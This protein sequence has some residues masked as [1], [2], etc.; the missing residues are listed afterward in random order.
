MDLI[1]Q[2]VSTEPEIPIPEVARSQALAADAALP[3]PPARA[4]ARHPLAHLLQVRG[5]LAGG[6]HKPNTAVAQAYENAKAGMTRITTET[7]AGQWGSR[8]R[9]PA[10]F[11]GLECKV[12]MV[13]HYDQK[14]YRRSMMETWG[15]SVLRSSWTST[16]PAARSAGLAG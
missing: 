4:R 2:E 16:G 14:P 15:A 12:Y 5:R 9:S 10:G 13:A 1:L 7:G 6:S 8:W 3:R 11:F